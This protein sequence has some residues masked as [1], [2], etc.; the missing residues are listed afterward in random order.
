MGLNWLRRAM[1]TARTG[2]HTR[3]AWTEGPRFSFLPHPPDR[4]EAGEQGRLGDTVEGSASR[5]GP[6]RAGVSAR[7]KSLLVMLA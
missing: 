7:N 6:G 4:R 5:H 2:D 1:A 3:W